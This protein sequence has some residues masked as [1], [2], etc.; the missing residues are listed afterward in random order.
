MITRS[1]EDKIRS[2]LTAYSSVALMGPRQRY[3]ASKKVC[4]LRRKVQVPATA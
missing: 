1:L 3:P 4:H 2:A